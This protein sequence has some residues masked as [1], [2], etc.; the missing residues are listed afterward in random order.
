MEDYEIWLFIL[1]ILFVLFLV[2]YLLYRRESVTFVE[3]MSE[4]EYWE[5]GEEFR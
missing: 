5:G 3:V 1:V 4:D 2:A